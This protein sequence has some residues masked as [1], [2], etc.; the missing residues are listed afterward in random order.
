MLTHKTQVLI[1]MILVLP[2]IFA[3]FLTIHAREKRVLI[4]TKNGEGYV[5]DNIAASV[6]ALTKICNENKI[7]TD[8]SDKP[9][10]FTDENLKQYQ[11]IIFSNTNNEA[12]DND[13]QRNAFKK[14]IQ[15]G[16]GFVGIHSACAS[17]RKWP[18]FW[19]MVGGLF[20]RHPKFQPFTI[21][22]IDHQHPATEF[23]GDTWA[24][25]DECYYLNHLNPDIHVLLAADLTTIDD[26]QRAE[27]PGET[28][29]NYF[30]LAWYHH[31]DGGREF[32]TALGHQIEHYKDPN[33]LKH[34]W[35]GIRWAMG[36]TH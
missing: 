33:F 3:Q 24:W 28:F 22:V 18:W 36:E 31:F 14:F 15:S 29:G 21:K 26:P 10:V 23:L 35:G 7:Q 13:D 25:E 30:P 32:F 34:L 5:H 11:V 2:F 16:K 1:Q 17:E 6:E 19:A 8:V 9:S 27:Y 4:Y 20:V 12:F